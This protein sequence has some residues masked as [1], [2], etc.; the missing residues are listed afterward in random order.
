MIAMSPGLSR[1]A[2]R[3][4]AAVEPGDPADA[5]ADVGAAAQGCELHGCPCCHRIRGG[6]ATPRG[7]RHRFADLR[8]GPRALRGSGARAVRHG[9]R[10]RVGEQLGG[11]LAGGRGVRAGEHAGQLG[12]P[13]V[14][15]DQPHVAGGDA[16]GSPARRRL[17]DDD[18]PVGEGRDL[19][20]VGD[21][22]HLPLAGPA[23]RAGGRPR[24]RPGRRRR[25]RPRRRPAWGPDRCRPG[26]PRGRASPGTA[27]R[28]TRRGPAAGPGRPGCGCS[29]SSTSSAPSAVGAGLGAGHDE[30][31]VRAPAGAAGHRTCERARRA[32]P[33]RPARR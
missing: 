7:R 29:S 31:R 17:V 6:P 8:A 14:A 5:R 16:V 21:D 19:G 3:G 11:V 23:G 30:G 26:T 28:R 32:W 18:V 9:P 1:P 24:P 25:R 12:D 20:Q 33:G 13:V 10:G 2:R 27:R 22:E 4:G 15:G